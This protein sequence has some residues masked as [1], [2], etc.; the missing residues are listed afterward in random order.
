MIVKKSNTQIKIG[1]K[2]KV[3]SEHFAAYFILNNR[4]TELIPIETTFEIMYLKE[5][6]IKIDGERIF[7]AKPLDILEHC[8]CLSKEKIN[9]F[10]IINP[11]KRKI[12]GAH[13]HIKYKNSIKIP[14]DEDI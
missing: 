8:I 4:Q 11:P 1:Q 14:K 10:E 9:L 12:R 3:N 2:W 6:H 13:S 7:F 5:W